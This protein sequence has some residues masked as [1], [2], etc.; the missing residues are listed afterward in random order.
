LL[1]AERVLVVGARAD[2]ITPVSHARRLAHHFGSRLESW[3]GGHLLQIGRSDKFRK[4]GQML[5]ELG[6]TTRAP[7]SA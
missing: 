1:A 7:R 5:D 6:L 2:Q 3:P 4:I